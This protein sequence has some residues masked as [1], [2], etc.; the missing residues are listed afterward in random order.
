[1]PL[2]RGAALVLLAIL[3]FVTLP[4]VFCSTGGA[5][6]GALVGFGLHVVAPPAAHTPALQLGR[7]PPTV[8][9]LADLALGRLLLWRAASPLA[10]LLYLYVNFVLV[11]LGLHA[12]WSVVRNFAVYTWRVVPLVVAG[13][14]GAPR[15]EPYSQEC[16]AALA[17]VRSAGDALADVAA[18]TELEPQLEAAATAGLAELL[19]R[20]PAAAPFFKGAAAAL[21]PLQAGAVAGTLESLVIWT[22]KWLMTLAMA[23]SIVFCLAGYELVQHEFASLVEVVSLVPWRSLATLAALWPLAGAAN[24]YL[25][26][27]VRSYCRGTLEA[28]AARAADAATPSGRAVL[29]PV[30]LVGDAEVDAEL[31]VLAANCEESQVAYDAFAVDFAHWERTGEARITPLVRR[32]PSAAAA[33]QTS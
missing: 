14:A 12:F 25:T 33:T 27:R 15:W 18:H 19:A 16:H 28:A 2:L 5:V 10:N 9:L 20:V 24:A 4:A 1:M 29:A 22:A 8:A 11:P 13:P 21:A 23:P 6:L 31:R 3:W 32:R 7:H 30:A 26:W 17:A